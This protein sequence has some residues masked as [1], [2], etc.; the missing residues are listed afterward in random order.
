MASIRRPKG[1]T[2]PVTPGSEYADL[3][4]WLS[5]PLEERNRLAEELKF[6]QLPGDEERLTEL[7]AAPGSQLEQLRTDRS[8]FLTDNPTFTG[9]N[10]EFG[11]TDKYL[12]PIG[13]GLL[14]VIPGVGSNLFPRPSDATPIPDL[15]DLLLGHPKAHISDPPRPDLPQLPKGKSPDLEPLEIPDTIV[16]G[17]AP[18]FMVEEGEIIDTRNRQ[19]ISQEAFEKLAKPDERAAIEAALQGTESDDYD[20]EAAK[21]AGVVPTPDASDIDPETGKPRLHWDSQFKKDHHR[22]R[23]IPSE[24]GIYDSK[25]N[26]LVPQGEFDRI[27]TPD[28]QANILEHPPL[29]RD[30][31]QGYLGNQQDRAS[32]A[33]PT[34]IPPSL[35]PGF[36]GFDQKIQKAEQQQQAGIPVNPLGR[37][38]DFE[39]LSLG[40]AF[41]E[42]GKSFLRGIGN[43]SGLTLKG[44]GLWAKE[45]DTLVGNEKKNDDYATYRLGDKI[46]KW[47]AKTFEGRPDLQSN[48][49]LTTLFE[50]AGSSVPFL[51][52]GAAGA[53]V[54]A[55]PGA[56]AGVTGALAG[57]A[58]LVE[59]APQN[60]T[61]EQKRMGLLLG[62]ALGATEG[63]PIADLF[64]RMNVATGGN[65]AYAAKVGTIQAIEEAVQEG[66]QQIGENAVVKYLYGVAGQSLSEGAIEGL[67]AGGLIGFLTG[68]MLSGKVRMPA[69]LPKGGE[70][71]KDRAT[72]LPPDLTPPSVSKE[73]PSKI[74]DRIN[75][76]VRRLAEQ[77]PPT[78][79]TQ[80]GPPKLIKNTPPQAVQPPSAQPESETQFD[81]LPHLTPQ[82]QREYKSAKERY[83]F[84]DSFSDLPTIQQ[85]EQVAKER[86]NKPSA[87]EI[88]PTLEPT[89]SQSVEQPEVTMRDKMGWTDYDA[90]PAATIP[91]EP[92]AVYGPE[93][94]PTAI[95]READGGGGFYIERN[96]GTY[97]YNSESKNALFPDVESAKAAFANEVPATPLP[98][99]LV[100]APGLPSPP[101]LAAPSLAEDVQA[102]Q[103]ETV[104]QEVGKQVPTLEES[105]VSG[106]TDIGSDEEFES[107]VK[108]VTDFAKSSPLPD[109]AKQAIISQERMLDTNE[110]IDAHLTDAQWETVTVPIDSLK[111]KNAVL[112]GR[113]FTH[114]GSISNGPIVLDREGEVIDGNNRLYEAIQRGDKTIQAYR[115]KDEPFSAQKT[116]TLKAGPPSLEPTKT[117]PTTVDSMVGPLQPGELP[118]EEFLQQTRFYRSGKTKNAQVPGGERV[119]LKNDATPSNF[120]ETSRKFLHG[121]YGNYIAKLRREKGTPKVEAVPSLEPPK[122]TKPSD[123][124]EYT[125]QPLRPGAPPETMTLPAKPTAK[126]GNISPL[127]GEM[128]GLASKKE[129]RATQADEA[130]DLIRRANA[131]LGEGDILLEKGVLDQEDVR[132]LRANVSKL[133]KRIAESGAPPSLEPPKVTIREAEL[134]PTRGGIKVTPLEPEPS[135]PVQALTEEVQDL[136]DRVAELEAKPVPGL[137]PETVALPTKEST[138]APTLDQ[139]LTQTKEQASISVSQS[140]ADILQ[141]GELIS[142]DALFKIADK[143]FGGT[144][145]QGAYTPKDAFDAVEL[146]VNLYILKNDELFYT[147]QSVEQAQNT[148]RGIRTRIL[149]KLPTPPNRRTA[150]QDE[151]QQ[152]STPPDLA[153]AMNWIAALER[154]SYASGKRGDIFLEPSAGLGGLAVFAKVDGVGTVYVN[155]RSQRRA[156]ILKSLP[157]DE[158]FT[159]NA[160]QLHNILPDT[161]KPTVIV[162]NPPFT[163]TAGRITG[164]RKTSNV[165]PHLEQALA[166]LEPGGRLVALIGK[167]KIYADPLVLERWLAKTAK[168]YAFRARIGLSGKGYKKYGTTYD[169]Q[170]LV[171]DKIEPTGQAPVVQDFEDVRD[172]LPVLKEVRDVRTKLSDAIPPLDALTPAGTRSPAVPDLGEGG[173]RPDTVES[174]ATSAMGLDE[175]RPGAPQSGLEESDPGTRRPASVSKPAGRPALPPQE[176]GRPGEPI[177]SSR[178]ATTGDEPQGSGDRGVQRPGSGTDRG[179]E[180]GGLPAQ[181]VSESLD[182][183][184]LDAAEPRQVGDIGDSVYQDYVPSK[185]RIKGAK[186]H[187]G[188]LQ[189][190]AALSAV[191]TANVS[192]LPKLPKS[193]IENGAV[194]LAQLEAVAYAG[195]AHT[196]V[197]PDGTRRGFFLGDGPGVGKGRTIAAMVMDN[198]QQG[199]KKAVWLS[200]TQNLYNSAIRDWKALGG[201][202]RDLA[203][204]NKVKLGAP[205]P[206]KQG[207]LFMTYSTLG[208]GVEVTRSGALKAKQVKGGKPDDLVKTR[209]DQLTQWLGADFDGIIIFDEAHNMQ[210]ALAEEGTMG[211]TQPAARALAGVELQKRFPNARFLYSSATGATKL[212]AL[213]YAERLGLWGSGTAFPKKQDF[214]TDIGQAGLGAMEIVAQ[215][216]KAQGS[217]ISRNLSYDGVTYT[218]IEH[219]LTSEQQAIY[220]E[221]G[222]AWQLVLGNI[223]QALEASGVTEEK[224]GQ[225]KTKNGRAKMAVMGRFWGTQLRFYNQI[226]NSLQ[227]PSVIKDMEQRLAN[228]ESVVVQLTNTDEA[229]LQR[230]LQKV[231]AGAVD[232]GAI[233]LTPRQDL[234]TFVRN[235]FPVTQFEDYADD[236]GN[237]RSRPVMDSQGRPVEN[238]EAVRMREDLLD[239]LGSLRVPD[240][241]I[242]I[243]LST[244]GPDQVA[245][246]TGRKERV[247]R[248]VNRAGE[249]VEER[250][251]NRSDALR[252]SEAAEF[253]ADKRRILIFSE[254]GGTGE[255]YHAELNS[256]NQRLRNHYLVQAGWRADKAVQGLGRT[257]RTNQKQPP[258]YILTMTNINGHKRF[259]STIARR[260]DQLGALTKGQRQ[261]GSS[262]LLDAK[263]NLEN[264]YATAAIRQLYKDALQGIIPDVTFDMISRKI[265]LDKIVDP[266]SGAFNET[267][268][269]DVPQFLN[270]LLTLELHEQNLVFEEFKRRMDQFIEVAASKGLL[271]VGMQT[272]RA[273]GGIKELGSEVIFTDPVSGAKTNLVELEASHK[274]QFV[275]A[276]TFT[277]FTKSNKTGKVFGVHD[278]GNRTDKDGTVT[279]TF[280]LSSHVAGKYRYIKESEYR[281]LYAPI[282]KKAAKAVWEQQIEGESATSTEQL[283]LVTGSLL[284]IWKRLPTTFPEITRLKTNEGVVHLG[285]KLREEAAE[286]LR[287][288]LGVK[289]Q[290]SLPKLSPGGYAD[291]VLEKGTTI[292]LAN[293]WQIKRS[294]V[295]NEPRMEVVGDNLY[296]SRDIL[297]KIGVYSER[298]NFATRYFVPTGQNAGEVMKRLM[299]V[300][301]VVKV[302][303]SANRNQQAAGGE[304]Q[305]SFERRIP[306]VSPDRVTGPP[307]SADF[308][309]SFQT[310]RPIGGESK[311]RLTDSSRQYPIGMIQDLAKRQHV[312]RLVKAVDRAYQSIKQALAK[313]DEAFNS[314]AFVGFSPDDYYAGVNI[315]GRT[316]FKT[317]IDNLMVLNPWAMVWRVEEAIKQGQIDRDQADRYLASH[318]IDTIIHELTHQQVR[319]HAD[320]QKF[321][322]QLGA[323]YD[324]IG[325]GTL[326]RA[327]DVIRDALKEQD[328]DVYTRLVSDLNDLTPFWRKSARLPLEIGGRYAANRRAGDGTDVAGE[329]TAGRT[330]PPDLVPGRGGDEA[331]AMGRRP[332]FQRRETGERANPPQYLAEAQ[333][334]RAQRATEEAGFSSSDPDIEAR[335]RAAKQ[336]L[337]PESLGTRLKAHAERVWRLVSREYE[338]LPDTA[339]F[340][341]LRTD[342]L[343]LQKYKGIAADKTQRDLAAIVKP[344]T[345][346]Q[347]DQLEWKALLS[348]LNREAEQ[349]RALPFG[350]TPEKV[351]DDLDRLNAV[352][353]RDPVV[354]DAWHKRQALWD[355]LKSDYQRSMEAIGFDTSKKLTKEDY[356]RHQVLAYSQERTLK[357]TGSTIRTPTGRGFLKARQG[358]G[359]DINAN[360]VQAEFEVMAQMVYD[361]QVAKVIKNVDRHYNIRRQLSAEAK[362]TNKQSIQALIDAGGEMGAI[363]EKAM[364]DFKKRIGMHMGMIRKALEMDKD[365]P[366][367]LEQVQEY[368]NDMES[369]ANLSARGVFKAIGE[370]K[371]FV[372]EVLGPK[373]VT[374]EQLIPETHDLWQPREGNVFYMA[375]SIPAQMAKA[376][377]EGMLQEINLTPD[378]LRKVMAMGN[379]RE[380]YV[381]PKEAKATLEDLSQKEHSFFVEINRSLLAHWKQIMLIAPRRIIRYNVR[382]LT[383]DADATFVGN[384]KAFAKY[385][386]AATELIPVIF[387]DTVLTGEAKEWAERGGYG[388]TLQIQELGDLNDLKAFAKTLDREAKGGWLKLPASA[389][390]RYWQAA[391][392]STDYREA[393]GRYAAYL[394]FLEQMR[395]NPQGR[396]ESFG[397]SKPETVMALRD[398]RDRAFKLSNELLGAYDRVGVAGQTLRSFWIPFWSWSEVNATRYLQLAKNAFDGQDAGSMARGAMIGTKQA[399]TFLVK[400]AAFWSMLQVWNLMM[401]GDDEDELRETNPIVANRPHI[402]FGRDE[403]GEIRYLAGIGALGDLLS[404]FGLDAFPGMVGDVMHDRLTIGE[405]VK[406]MA[407]APVNKIVNSVTPVVKI[408]GETIS[409]ETYYPDVFHPRPIQNRGDYLG[410]QTTFGPEIQA[411]QGKPGKPLYESEDLTGLLV[412]RTDPKASAYSTWQGIERKYMERAG[413]EDTSLFWRSPRGQALNNWSRAIHQAD[414]DAIA[415]WKDEYERMER[416]KYGRDFSLS[417]MYADMEKSLRAKAPLAGVTKAERKAI[418]AQLDSQERRTLAKAEAYYKDVLLQ[419]LPPARRQGFE[420][421]LERQGWIQR[422]QVFPGLEP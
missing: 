53:A 9:K 285:I 165:F 395:A 111:K 64:Q 76:E 130:K 292:E 189:E 8:R 399:A 222:R 108:R 232:I 144:Q 112:W 266:R 25:N 45:L 147:N 190:S 75:A 128:H 413:K 102:Q 178:P 61:P 13:K 56:M 109:Y 118:F 318:L 368:A 384:P 304:D 305:P 229:A 191:E 340:S 157:F 289:A 406:N 96:D 361:T 223:R 320:E 206:M 417:K 276:E 37:Y 371:A 10:K 356:F 132:N 367:T 94:D 68:F 93:D 310:A 158:V 331:S 336:G 397:A 341:P 208:S 319:T 125:V 373:H 119:I 281:D 234:M 254:K 380:Q 387:K 369:P 15:G 227:M 414:D 306:N 231:D 62:A 161:V 277:L 353:E 83:E 273:S 23:F 256:K 284:N 145:A 78:L 82:E 194:S 421:K 420:R 57:G 11:I 41:E 139:V 120:R 216:L 241:P 6:G 412:Q 28:Q 416:E 400:M 148:I 214:L 209:L 272:F 173:G 77:F 33:V 298:I 379:E 303:R 21:K 126:K 129:F 244:F 42:S 47:T 90:E 391:R 116:L 199:R 218:K 260:L 211:T 322:Q 415:Q 100:Q 34:F 12:K 16:T 307:S 314:L 59:R 114:R 409:R 86:A 172:A 332:A 290:K 385:K 166:R 363:L 358:S 343:R 295:S 156:D 396:P 342:L 388:S 200:E 131:L 249:Q 280:R 354:Q 159:E 339:E 55:G 411:L 185:F 291:E 378:T 401:Y 392:L 325:M 338:N 259:I 257:H 296:G 346:K 335:V 364:K 121:V 261:A 316:L 32:Q 328:T 327:N 88:P 66:V 98:P 224:N 91:G 317:P 106:T 375:D 44:I 63:V 40:G 217:Y 350:Y 97:V 7:Y 2:P 377:Q 43:T 71:D 238:K 389:W 155:E 237:I 80:K 134:T 221:M 54:G 65:L 73:K 70:E 99:G 248:Y 278:L 195:Q 193:L 362:Q 183:D 179:S 235:A 141:R 153:F 283:A 404:W 372:K 110:G 382:N 162:M 137:T 390:N 51:A 230:E 243:I 242:D 188:T 17:D 418:V 252:R 174:P 163:S 152:F 408:L 349:D 151:F 297:E 142:S 393:I 370:R 60:A 402:L 207:V 30:E 247:V 359:L 287:V 225:S 274:T 215:N 197:L 196:Q 315:S 124:I 4:D 269:P 383:G 18:R 253:M 135:K 168:Q 365:E 123:K 286:Q 264:E 267:G 407:K 255:S 300:H 177:S 150:E 38:G 1:L 79:E 205:I 22:N 268:V 355:R 182:L 35:T 26:R 324:K 323:N 149:D 250:E 204:I 140:V 184:T 345:R 344:L 24:L 113:T 321:E 294:R 376:L 48:F 87:T 201:H 351:R 398:I 403:D 84:G 101:Q 419:V 374:W 262:G 175:R 329:G 357:G 143:A 20:Y 251:K 49:L 258:R 213:A 202:E 81:P 236:D 337:K 176:S 271:D 270:R 117:V 309:R 138:E 167:G 31:V 3:D 212:S 107:K 74:G 299:D 29:P 169:N 410:Q 58:G 405:A 136:K 192:Y 133:E 394:S 19:I 104:K 347:Y 210:N 27:A 330:G 5:T 360:Y 288:N 180:R 275:P 39:P 239:K 279:H 198:W 308:A 171:F 52:T 386:Q 89:P 348:D 301:P 326:M 311:L 50:G 115:I 105:P 14:D 334:Y 240:S 187:P 170:I 92:L 263:D 245:E 233:D 36:E 122:A 352:I 312:H 146:G 95:L 154:K 220:N 164:Q 46:G 366:L 203:V 381:I 302:L 69:A 333:R 72:V 313:T 103:Q 181:Q 422:P 186:P 293:G 282:D 228:G 246:I 85:L 226:L 127:L 219:E 265:G 160:E 67:G